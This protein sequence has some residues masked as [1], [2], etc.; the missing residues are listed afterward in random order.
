MKKFKLAH[1]FAIW[2]AAMFVLVVFTQPESR[3]DKLGN[4][5]F[6]VTESAELYFRNVRSYHY[7]H[8]QEAGDIFDVY[9]L[10]SLFNP[11]ADSPPLLP[12]TIY[13]N[14]RANE[15]FIRLDTAFTAKSAVALVADSAGIS[16]DRGALPDATN[17]AQYMFAVSVY[18]AL[19]DDLDIALLTEDADTV[20][21]PDDRR[22]AV[23]QV[24][25]DYFKLTGKL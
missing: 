3:P 8:N 4:I 2:L 19:R 21:I 15:A 22:K 16:S 23:R 11:D 17:E 12:F 6:S 10:K 9:R 14:W 13:N 1:W 25:T 20:R 5:D 7:L 24:L 18:R